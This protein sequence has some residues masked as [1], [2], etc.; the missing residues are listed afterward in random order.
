[1]IASE[2][3][4]LHAL[5]KNPNLQKLQHINAQKEAEHRLARKGYFPKFSITAAY[6]QRDNLRIAN[7]AVY[8]QPDNSGTADKIRSDMVSLLIGFDL[9]IWFKRKQNRK[10]S[11]T[12]L[13]IEQAK[14]EFESEKN[15]IRWKHIADVAA[16]G[17]IIAYG[18]GRIG[19]QVSGDGDWGIAN[20]ATKPDWLGFLP[21]WIWSYTFPHNI[22]NEG[23][24]IPGCIGPHCFELAQ[25]V[26]PTAFYETVMTVIIFSILWSL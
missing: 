14:S 6:G 23:I 8:P 19:C 3:L 18:I 11:E 24:P 10:V 16:P 13:L 1:M 25:G 26:Y 12:K 22:I 5:E 4:M 15:N 7:T 9:P 2:D 17:L 21:D 20:A